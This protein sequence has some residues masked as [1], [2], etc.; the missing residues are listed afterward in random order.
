MQRIVIM[1]LALVLSALVEP[2]A[3]QSVACDK[4]SL[5]KLEA[6]IGKIS[7]KGQKK[8]M[9]Q[10]TRAKSAFDAGDTKK[11][12]RIMSRIAKA[13]GQTTTTGTGTQTAREAI[14]AANG[15]FIEDF[16]AK[17]A[18]GAVAHYAEDAAAFPP[19]QPRVDG[20]ENIQK[21]WQAVIDAGVTD[22]TLTIK[23]VEEEGDLAVESGT[24]S[25][26]APGKD[27][28]PA[29]VVGKYVVVW[30]KSTDGTWQLYRD[31]WNADS[32]GK[33]G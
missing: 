12:Q 32:A 21:M 14:E 13:T 8:A 7:G 19:D 28:N 5:A 25:L 27:G 18:E 31:I 16:N 26:K 23:D 11:C 4:D 29:D 24:F 15:E 20:R 6:D 30:K 3:A 1:A 22:L 17:D 33:G 9:R 2:A 10:L